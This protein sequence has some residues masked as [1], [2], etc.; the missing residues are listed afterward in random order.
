MLQRH[1][2]VGWLGAQ[3]F[4]VEAWWRHARH[5]ERLTLDHQLRA[6]DGRVAAIHAL[7]RVVR[8][9]HHGACGRR[10]VGCGERAAHGRVHAERREVGATHVDGAEQLGRVRHALAAHAHASHAGLKRGELVELRHV[11][12]DALEEREREHAPAILRTALHA[13]GAPVADAIEAR[14]I[15]DRER[16]QHHRMNERED[17]GGPAD[18]DRQRQD[19]RDGERPRR[20][21]RAERVGQV[22]EKSPHAGL[23]PTTQLSGHS[24]CSMICRNG[25]R[26]A[27]V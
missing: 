2:H 11:C 9:H 8:Q 18:A 6:D 17:R 22:A 4:T 1:P 24:N 14:G 16:L 25:R 7:P 3:R 26:R 12:L 15:H 27:G 5:R 20:T 10:I 13:A 21:K 23:N 19:G